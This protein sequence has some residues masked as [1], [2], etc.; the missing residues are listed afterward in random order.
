ML[1]EEEL[2]DAV[3]FEALWDAKVVAGQASPAQRLEAEEMDWGGCSLT[4]W[5]R[6]IVSVGSHN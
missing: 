1:E 2:V 5:C 3:D 4:S 6:L